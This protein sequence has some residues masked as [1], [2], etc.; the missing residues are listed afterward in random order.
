MDAQGHQ[1]LM[2][3]Q[4]D[5]DDDLHSGALVDFRHVLP[6]FTRLRVVLDDRTPGGYVVPTVQYGH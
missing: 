3:H 6:P 5:D 1:K 2:N 4:S